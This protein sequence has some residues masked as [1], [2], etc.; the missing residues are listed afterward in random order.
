MNDEGKSREQ[1]LEELAEL[2]RRLA[3][4]HG[5]GSDTSRDDGTLQRSEHYY[6]SLIRNAGDMITVLNPDLTLRWG[7]RSSGRITGYA[8]MELYGKTLKDLI[9][10]EDVDRVAGILEEAKEKPGASLYYEHRFR[11]ADGSYHVHEAIVTNLLDDPSVKALVVNSHDIS[12]RKKMEQE[13]L[14]RNQELDAFAYTVSHDL[15]T[16]LALIEGY[17]QLMRAEDTTDLE[18]EGYLKSIIAAARRMNDLTESLLEY[19]QAGQP[20]GEI[21][22][23]DPVKVINEVLSDQAFA[24]ELENIEVRVED[25]LP[26]ILVDSLKLRQVFANLLSNAVKYIAE[27]A[28]PRIEIGAKKDMGTVTFHVHDNGP[29]IEPGLLEEVFQPFKRFGGSTSY[30][31]GIGLSTVKR[32]VEGWGGEVWVESSQGQGTTFFFTAPAVED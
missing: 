2:R 18:K 1:L 32:A 22:P 3:E 14:A 17:A 23:V 24:L 9:H 8:S 13:L 10:P 5:A 21:A 12:Q 15:R 28:H 26:E 31:K 29:G 11:H 16:P 4:S 30:G 7:S 19:A 27:Y 6:R 25:G 20:G